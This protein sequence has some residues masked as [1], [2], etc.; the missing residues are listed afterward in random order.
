MTT[1]TLTV[2]KRFL[3]GALRGL[4]ITDRVT[5]SPAPIGKC[6]HECITNALVQIVSIRK[7]GR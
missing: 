4:T 2:K 1:H 5:R 7:E 6:Y 3:T